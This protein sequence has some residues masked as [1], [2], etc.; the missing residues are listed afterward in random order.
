MSYR[1]PHSPNQRNVPHTRVEDERQLE[2]SYHCGEVLG[3]GSFGVVYE[4]VQ[5]K[6]GEKFAIKVIHKEK[7]SQ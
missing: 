3:K 1:P 2:E 6:S 7:V 4:A 5:K